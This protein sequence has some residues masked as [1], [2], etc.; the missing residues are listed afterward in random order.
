[1]RYLLFFLDF[2]RRGGRGGGGAEEPPRREGT[3]EGRR[4]AAYKG[5]KAAAGLLRAAAEGPRRVS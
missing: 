3:A 2:V 5:E 4:G 1:M